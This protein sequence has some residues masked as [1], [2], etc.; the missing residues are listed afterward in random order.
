MNNTYN[1]SAAAFTFI[2]SLNAGRFAGR[3]D[4]RL[5]SE[6]GLNPPGTGP[7]ELET[8]VD[9]SHAP[10]IDPIFGPTAAEAYWSS[11]SPTGDPDFAWAVHFFVGF[12]EVDYKTFPAH[13]RAVRGGP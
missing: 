4:W 11:S 10:T 1:W 2:G 7:R 13:A 3:S 12:V 8:I 5:P 6:D 9:L